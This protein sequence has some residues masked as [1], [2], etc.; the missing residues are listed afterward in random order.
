MALARLVLITVLVT[1]AVAATAQLAPWSDEELT[2]YTGSKPGALDII[3]IAPESGLGDAETL[4]AQTG[5][6]VT[7]IPMSDTA[8]ELGQK[9]KLPN[10]EVVLVSNVGN[11]PPEALAVAMRAQLN[12]GRGVVLVRYEGDAPVAPDL[13]EHLA[14]VEDD[15]L[16]RGVLAELG[17]R[18]PEIS[19]HEDKRA[20]LAVITF[21]S[22]PPLSHCMVARPAEGAALYRGTYD[23]A[24]ALPVRAVLWAA[25]QTGDT[26][27]ANVTIPKL[28]EPDPAD[29]P[30]GFEREH[31]ELLG[32]LAGNP[33]LEEFLVH[34]NRPLNRFYE[35]TARIRYPALGFHSSYTLTL[36]KGIG[37][38][39]MQVPIGFHD[40]TADFILS[41]GG[42]TR[43]WYSLAGQKFGWPY[44]DSVLF[45]KTVVA[46]NDTMSVTATVPPHPV[47]P[48]RGRLWLRAQDSFG[49]VVAMEH[50]AF[51]AAAGQITV[52][53]DLKGLIAPGL[54]VDTYAIADD[55]ETLSRAAIP[56]SA[57]AVRTIEV[58][59]PLEVPFAFAARTA[60]SNEWGMRRHYEALRRA[61][62]HAV[63]APSSAGPDNAV[64]D[65]GL[66]APRALEG[67]DMVT[68]DLAG[69]TPAEASFAVW[70]AALAQLDGVIVHGVEQPILSVQ[71]D[72]EEATAWSAVV[73]SM[74]RIH[75]GL[76]RVLAEAELLA[77]GVALGAEDDVWPERFSPAKPEFQG[78]WFEFQWGEA[79]FV[80]LLSNPDSTRTRFAFTSSGSNHLYLP[81]QAMQV[82]PGRKATIEVEPGQAALIAEL[83][84]ETSRIVVDV[85]EVC[86]AGSFLTINVEVKTRDRLP[87]RH[88]FSLTL[89]RPGGTP[90][91]WYARSTLGMD[92]AANVRLPLAINEALGVHTVTVNDIL[93]GTAATAEFSVLPR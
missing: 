6:D 68:V 66:F 67:R 42:E 30:P 31:V 77:R 60:L 51:D 65:A 87:G 15:S 38:Y 53:A 74:N 10:A 21:P 81:F 43:D 47:N 7:P 63:V 5:A 16:L 37:S 48:D 34:F 76:D 24:M 23:S 59:L 70:R 4:A 28:P 26:W 89:Q 92:G 22:A 57:A 29:I 73:A 9:R 52:H 86:R 88:A 40:Y 71:N 27:I 56:R 33:Q 2:W 17:H 54:L 19:L 82:A 78:E 44:F 41:D 58:D 46:P 8:F 25:R 13:L 80:A 90:L 11:S 84:Y 32:S 69:V 49:R 45:A 85:D 36:E 20:R 18:A 64:R 83:P 39:A 79:Y 72:R 12:R 75:G 1:S 61:G 50:R 91:P 93:T 35:L 3:V 14:P 62:V 55:R